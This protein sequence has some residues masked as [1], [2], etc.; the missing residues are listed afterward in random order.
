MP[1]SFSDSTSV[2]K[3]GFVNSLDKDIWD[4]VKKYDFTI[5]TQDSDFN[6]LNSLLGFP[7][8]VIW[9]RTGDLSS[10]QLA[11]ILI[12]YFEEIERFLDDQK[13]GCL[14]IINIERS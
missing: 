8:K 10:K 13:Y 5:V 6:N 7:P 14:E 2:K 1:G 11:A 4:Y 12:E 3:E 9:I